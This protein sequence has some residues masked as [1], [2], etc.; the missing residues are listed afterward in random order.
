MRRNRER[1]AHVAAHGPQCQICGL[2]PKRGLDQDHDHRTGATRGWLC[3]AC[4]RKLWSGVTS[5]WLRD[6]ADYL[7]RAE[8]RAGTAPPRVSRDLA[9]FAATLTV[10]ELRAGILELRAMRAT[11]DGR[12]TLHEALL[13]S[14]LVARLLV[15]T[16]GRG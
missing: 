12:L 16:K 10:D 4:N 2:V 7:E 1:A 3:H 13:L 5:D 6:A 11:A 14:E 15:V 9:E 8:D